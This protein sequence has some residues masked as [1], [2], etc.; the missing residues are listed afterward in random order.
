MNEE[1][2][3]LTQDEKMWG[4]FCHLSAIAGYIIPFGNIIGPL[5]VWMIKK[6]ESQFVNEHGKS[7]LNFEISIT[8]YV[9]ISV[10]LIFVVI[11]IP[12]LIALGVFQIV[13]VI[14]ASVRAL[15]GQNYRYPLTMTFV[16]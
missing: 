1:A 6:E 8:I 9:L 4:M 15:D 2:K 3:P 14:I 13:V 10:L 11:G 7:S 12:I 5:V 16:N